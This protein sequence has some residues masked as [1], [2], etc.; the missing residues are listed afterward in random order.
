MM[1]WSGWGAA[2]VFGMMIVMLAFLAL[3]VGGLTLFF[4]Q[5]FGGGSRG[6]PILAGGQITDGVGALKRIEERYARGEMS[7]EEFLA[8]RRE[9]TGR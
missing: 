7:R 9:L 4:R 6:A 2:G 8:R 5:V 3:V 1:D